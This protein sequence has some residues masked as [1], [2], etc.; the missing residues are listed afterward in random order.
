MKTLFIAVLFLCA[1]VSESY[2]QEI[3]TET[4][5]SNLLIKENLLAKNQWLYF[6]W[7]EDHPK[8]ISLMGGAVYPRRPKLAKNDDHSWEYSKQPWHKNSSDIVLFLL[9]IDGSAPYYPDET[10]PN[11]R[12]VIE[13]TLAENFLPFPVS[14]WEKDDIVI[15]ITHVGRRILNASVNAVYTQVTLTNKG[16]VSH[17]TQLIINGDYVSERVFPTNHTNLEKTDA[18]TLNVSTV[19]Q[20]EGRVIY[21]FVLP[22]N[23]HASINDILRE[24]GFSS[25]YAKERAEINQTISDLTYPVSLPYDELINLWRSSMTHMWNATVK[26]P[27]DYEQRGSGGNVYGFYQYDRVFDHDVPDMVIQYIIE[28]KWDVARAIMEGATYSRLSKG[29]LEKEKYNDAIPKYLTTM[30]QYL[31]MTGDKS[32]FSNTLFEKIKYCAHAVH[33]M[34]KEQ[35]SPDLEDSRA[36]GLILK[37][38]TLDNGNEYL[39]VDNFAALHGFAAYKYVCDQLGEKAESQWAKAEMEDLNNCLNMALDISLKESGND[40]YNA[41]FSFDYDSV[42]V[43]GPGN[44]LGTTL[45]MPSFPWN[46]Y[47]KGFELGGTWKDHFDNSVAEWIEQGKQFGCEE[48]SFGAWWGAKYGAVYNAG[49]GM[50]LLF[51]DKYRTLT[52]QSIEWLLDNQSSP[53]HWGESFHKP[54]PASDWTRPDVDL[55]TWGLGF[56]RQALLQLCVSVHIDGTIILGRG[57]PDHW[58]NSGKAIAWKNVYINNGKKMDFSIRKSKNKIYIH[59]SGDQ[60]DGKI[61]LDLPILKGKKVWKSGDT[62]DFVIDLPNEE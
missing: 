10:N 44:W 57:I 22:A 62:K 40:W 46:A 53:Y 13:W 7:I 4:Q 21:E 28:G 48:G 14:Q 60:A 55:E 11:R 17:Q 1:I 8:A 20:P 51:S 30:A 43:S 19:L 38:S 41:C 15:Q 6:G 27:T 59:I 12:K 39:I 34:R 29:V 18:H 45:M 24:E 36:Y 42:L 47:L 9:S 52:A 2:S 35:L 33:D 54:H 25:Q 58:L 50:P 61:I 16:S 37:G 5:A 32:Y 23:G 26:T 3:K 56:I 49:M 31:Q